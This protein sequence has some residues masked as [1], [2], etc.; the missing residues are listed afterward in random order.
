LNA[1]KA[2]DEM[3]KGF[4]AVEQAWNVFA[5]TFG[6]VNIID[7]PAGGG[8]N[9]NFGGDW[10]SGIFGSSEKPKDAAISPFELSGNTIGFN[11]EIGGD[12]SGVTSF[13]ILDGTQADMGKFT[14]NLNLM[15]NTDKGKS[16]LSGNTQASLDVSLG[17]GKNSYNP[18]SKTLYM[19]FNS[20]IAVSG[21]RHA[22]IISAPIRIQIHELA[23]VFKGSID[24]GQKGW[25]MNLDTG[26]NW[27]NPIM[28]Q[29]GYATQ[30]NWRNYAIDGAR[31]LGVKNA[32][33]EYRT[34]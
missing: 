23:H 17:Q 2:L 33:N 18:D 28:K 12:T 24:Y 21:M 14:N 5:N 22:K 13:N 19:N 4:A 32:I 27:S 15:W 7:L 11:S 30:R 34:R 25:K 29:M 9:Q 3:N 8:T 1:Q 20:R 31:G 26:K 16:L 6:Q 10:L